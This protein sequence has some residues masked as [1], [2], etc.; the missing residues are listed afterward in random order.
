MLLQDINGDLASQVFEHVSLFCVIMIPGICTLTRRW[1]H[2]ING[3]Y[4]SQTRALCLVAGASL[5]VCKRYTAKWCWTHQLGQS[6]T[7]IDPI[8]VAG[9]QKYHE[10]M[11]NVL[12][13][14]RKIEGENDYTWHDFGSVVEEKISFYGGWPIF[15][16]EITTDAGVSPAGGCHQNKGFWISS[17]WR[18]SR[19]EGVKLRQR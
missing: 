7:N 18:R 15:L 13:T 8:D 12:G 16:G 9:V 1:R 4:A 10:T 19:G 14:S 3:M 5:E 11:V 6:L 2:P 17:F